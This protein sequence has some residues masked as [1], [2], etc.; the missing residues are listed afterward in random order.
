MEY[1]QPQFYH[2]NE[3]SL[4]LVRS[5][6]VFKNKPL[7]VLDVGAGA[8]VIGIEISQTIS[9]DSVTFIEK[10]QEFIQ[11]LE[12]NIQRFIPKTNS[13]ILNID[14]ESHTIQAKYDLILSNPPYFNFGNGRVSE[15]FKRQNCRTFSKGM[16]LSRWVELCMKLLANEGEF[17]LVTRSENLKD[18][19]E[20]SFEVLDKTQ[21]IVCLKFTHI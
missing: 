2:F 10:E 20:Y 17:Y 3:D 18:I 14:L 11:Y 4:N 6:N 16:S 7:K 8:G 21:K 1:S 19:D 12:K 9:V 15:N 5:V 13:T